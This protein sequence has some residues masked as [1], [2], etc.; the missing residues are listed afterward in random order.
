MA[1]GLL[2]MSTR[3][4][5]GKPATEPLRQKFDNQNQHAGH[6][7]EGTLHISPI[8]TWL[9]L[10]RYCFAIAESGRILWPPS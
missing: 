6:H 10:P 7:K 2:D 1:I 5:A 8:S 4:A 3:S 9:N